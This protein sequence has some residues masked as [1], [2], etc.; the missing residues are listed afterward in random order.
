MSEHLRAS[1]PQRYEEISQHLLEQARREL[2]QGDILQASEKVWGATAHAIKAVAQQR[3]WNH[4]A[5]NNLREAATYIGFE[6]NR[7]ELRQ[8]FGYL[9][10]FHHNYYEHQRAEGDVRDAIDGAAVFVSEMSKL[11]REDTPDRQDHLSPSDV[12]DQEARLRRLTTKT[13]YS[14]GDA[15]REDE[16]ENLPPVRPAPAQ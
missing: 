12:T 15:Y 16:L 7:Q 1:P 9:E 4:H 2:D 3:G 5:H 10:A 8:L 13:R 11:R 14:H 6:Y